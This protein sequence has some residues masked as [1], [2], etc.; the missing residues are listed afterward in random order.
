MVYSRRCG[1]YR[2]IDISTFILIIR[3]T[4]IAI[5]VGDDKRLRRTQYRIE[6]IDYRVRNGV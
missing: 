1:K 2:C 6:F 3:N 4:L 5:A